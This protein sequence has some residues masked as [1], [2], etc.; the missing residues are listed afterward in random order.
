MRKEKYSPVNANSHGKRQEGIQ[1]TKIT[2]NEAASRVG[3][4]NTGSRN[5]SEAKGKGPR[6][7]KTVG[8]T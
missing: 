2:T 7:N 3:T 4:V 8:K 6:K 5:E 1:Y